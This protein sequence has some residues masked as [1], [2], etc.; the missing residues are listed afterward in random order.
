MTPAS[1]SA[2]LVGIDNLAAATGMATTERVW[3]LMLVALA[4][5]DREVPMGLPREDWLQISAHVYDQVR[6]ALASGEA[7]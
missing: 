3:A 1:L 6:G 7:S 2:S 5:I 4:I